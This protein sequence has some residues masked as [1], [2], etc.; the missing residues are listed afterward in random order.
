MSGRHSGG[1]ALVTVVVVNYNGGNLVLECLAA[2]R[3]QTCRDFTTVVV[4]NAS[5][6]NSRAAIVALFPEVRLLAAEENL[7]F[8]KG[9]NFALAQAVHSTWLA[10]LNPDASPEPGWLEALLAAAA[11]HP[12]TAAFGSQLLMCDAPTRLD[13]I[14]DVYH[15]SGLVWRAGFGRLKK[16]SDDRPREIF[17]PCAAAALYRTSIVR[18]LGGMDE[19]LF[20]Y[21]ED[22][23]LGFRLR[24][25]GHGCRYVPTAVVCHK[26]SAVAGF[27]SD[28]QTYHSHRNVVRVFVKNMPGALF[29]LFLPLHLVMNLVTLAGLAL[30]GR[31]RAAWRAKTD[32]LSTLSQ[33]WQARAAVQATRQI[34]LLSLLRRLTWIPLRR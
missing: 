8:A 34:S 14:G 24:L 20:C 5:T 11:A 26:G 22:V 16:R 32:A 9:V 6:D 33:A 13:G 12:Q 10:L 27:H 30:Q 7:G 23:D 29:W 15:V 17:S 1:E 3:R 2:L 18:S 19:S 4:D 31:G 25:A 21:L 28:F